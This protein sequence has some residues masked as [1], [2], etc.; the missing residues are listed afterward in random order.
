[1][2]RQAGTAGEH[3]TGIVE[4][5]GADAN[6]V[7]LPVLLE[8]FGAAVDGQRENRREAWVRAGVREIREQRRL[9]AVAGELEHQVPA[10]AAGRRK[11]IQAGEVNRR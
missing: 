11:R 3:E 6:D 4:V 8:C 10:G 9:V 1:M 5:P 7:R 2:H